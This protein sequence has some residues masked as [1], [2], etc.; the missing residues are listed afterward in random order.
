MI[1]LVNDML[2]ADRIEL[3]GAVRV[4][5]VRLADIVDNVL[6][7]LLLQ[8]KAW[9]SHALHAESRKCPKSRLIQKLRAVFRICWKIH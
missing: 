6:F 5:L 1:S 4:L 3:K 2:G 7:E 8:A 9:N